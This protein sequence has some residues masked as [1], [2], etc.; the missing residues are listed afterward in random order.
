MR[1]YNMTYHYYTSPFSGR[2]SSDEDSYELY[3]RYSNWIYSDDTRDEVKNTKDEIEDIR[4]EIENTL[5][6]Y[7][8]KIKE[9]ETKLSLCKSRKHEKALHRRSHLNVQ[10]NRN[11]PSYKR[12]RQAHICL[13]NM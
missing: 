5:K 7:Y 2:F 13:R 10:T 1:R 11:H 6:E 3:E 8:R 12:S 9:K 4:D